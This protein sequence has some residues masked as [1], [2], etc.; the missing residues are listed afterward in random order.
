MHRDSLARKALASASATEAEFVRRAQDTSLPVQPQY[1]KHT[2][3]VI[4][5]YSIVERPSKGIILLVRRRSASIGSE[6]GALREEWPDTPHRATGCGG[7]SG[8]QRHETS[9]RYPG[10]APR[11]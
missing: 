8:T 5:E 9:A 4:V 6:A 11:T 2:I 7:R 10:P 3:D 1:A